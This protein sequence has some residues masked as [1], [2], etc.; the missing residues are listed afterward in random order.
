[1]AAI[2][3][4][5]LNNG[6]KKPGALNGIV[7]KLSQ[8]LISSSRSKPLIGTSK[9]TLLVIDDYL[10]FYDKSSGSK[11]LFELL[12]LFISMDF[13]VIYL[14]EDG[15]APQP[16]AGEMQAM[17]IEILAITPEK[18]HV[19][20]LKERLNE[21]HYAWI[22]RPTLNKKYQKI[23]NKNTKTIFDTVDLHYLRMLRQAENE[24][25]E[26][27]KRRSLKTK[28]LELAL[29]LNSNATVTVTGIEKDILEREGID[30]VFVIPNVHFL[31][32]NNKNTP[33]EER[34]GILFIGGYKHEPNVDAVRW[35]VEEIMPK[36]WAADPTIHLTLLGSDPSKELLA[37]NSDRISVPGYLQEVADYFYENRIFVAP[38]RYGA[39]M[40]GKIGQSM[41][42]GLPVVSTSIG[43]EG[44][45]LKDGHNVLVAESTNDFANRILQL[46]QNPE[47]WSSIKNNSIKAIEDYSP[48]EVTK[49]LDKL[50][51]TL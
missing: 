22:S 5:S 45:D 32:P 37:Y 20:Q 2:S 6:S 38:L 48:A 36:V 17:G 9:K 16:Y 41:E 21:F 51:K 7:A 25:N 27:L 28:K 50:F 44:M 40:K 42:F 43:V 49:K 46:Y 39:G 12:K 47:L 29:A 35:L 26:K 8:L 15:K 31:N 18:S 11:R 14:P 19:D 1:M 34:K 30:H 3:N 33:F 13:K 23:L 10:P 4:S 24:G